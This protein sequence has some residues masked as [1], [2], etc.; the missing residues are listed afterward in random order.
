MEL[1]AKML[2]VERECQQSE[3]SVVKQKLYSTRS[4]FW[5]TVRYIVGVKICS[6]RMSHLKGLRRDGPQY[7]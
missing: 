2:A 6:S 4:A 1:R 3:S 5:N 7:E